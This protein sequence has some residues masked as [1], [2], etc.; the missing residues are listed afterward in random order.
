MHLMAGN[1]LIPGNGHRLLVV[2]GQEY[3]HEYTREYTGGQ[4]Q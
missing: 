1:K 4:G 2:R 3:I